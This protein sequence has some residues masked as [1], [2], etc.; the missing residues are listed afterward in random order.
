[1]VEMKSRKLKSRES[2]R[3]GRIIGITLVFPEGVAPAE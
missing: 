3:Q 2:S 1:M